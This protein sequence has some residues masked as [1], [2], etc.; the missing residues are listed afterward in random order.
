[1]EYIAAPTLKKWAST[2][3]AGELKS[4]DEV[5]NLAAS[6]A[7]PVVRWLFDQTVPSST[8]GRIPNSKGCVQHFF[9]KDNEAPL[10]FADANALTV[11]ANK[12]WRYVD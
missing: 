4:K 5:V 7:A 8:F 1:M 2:N 3:A 11:Y 12:V 9:F 6:V 10:V